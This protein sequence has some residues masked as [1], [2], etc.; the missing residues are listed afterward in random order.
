MLLFNKDRID[1]LIHDPNFFDWVLKPTEA[2]NDFW[3]NYIL[4]NPSAKSDIEEARIFIKGLV[5]KDKGLREEEIETLWN[6]IEETNSFQKKKTIILPRWVVAASI[7]FVLGIS[8]M[9]ILQSINNNLSDVDYSA[10]V[11]LEP[12]GNDV[13]LF[14]SDST[15]EVFS[16]NE[17]EIRYD[18]KGGILTG[19]GKV[20]GSDVVE[21]LNEEEQLNQ[22]VVPFGKHSNITLSDGTKLWLNSGSRA[23]YPVVFNKKYREIFIEG[24][25]YLEVAHNVSQPFFVKTE[26]VKVKVL[27]TIFNISAYSNESQSSVVLVEGSVQAW[28]GK[29]KVVIEPNQVFTLEKPSGEVSLKKNVN[30]LEYISWK[31]GWLLCKKEKMESIVTKLSR[32]YNVKIESMDDEINN[33]TL[34]GK[35][36]L[37]T[38]LVDVLNSITLTAPVKYEIDGEIVR[39]YIK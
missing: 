35:L 6:R 24:E 32:Y 16:S 38:E 23:I 11:R 9:L 14:L 21:K 5:K 33:L 2:L 3:N 19:S 31:D 26:K 39:L 10:V 18:E 1:F 36:D 22:L 28:V 8:G 13:T 29:D 17:V 25:A 7:V 27:G 20:L 4:Q 37:K 15:K 30:V 12:T 34:S